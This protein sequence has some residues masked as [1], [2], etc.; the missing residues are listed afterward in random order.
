[1]L[2]PVFQICS[3]LGGPGFHSP[4]A[5]VDPW[6]SLPPY[7]ASPVCLLWPP[8]P[9][10]KEGTVVSLL[11]KIYFNSLHSKEA[12]CFNYCLYKE[13]GDTGMDPLQPPPRAAQMHPLCMKE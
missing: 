1:M 8:H 11:G 6:P 2:G 3:E 13:A 5:P 4:W 9:G 7:G 12:S 10:L